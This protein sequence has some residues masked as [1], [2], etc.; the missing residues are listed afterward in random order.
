[1]IRDKRPASAQDKQHIVRMFVAGQSIAEIV[2]ETKAGRANIE[3]VLRE[4]ITGMAR[5]LKQRSEQD[6]GDS[7]VRLN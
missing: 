6:Q 3:Q 5:L 2:T 7:R 4:A 1:M